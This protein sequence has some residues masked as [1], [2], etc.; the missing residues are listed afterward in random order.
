MRL[1]NKYLPDK[2]YNDVEELLERL[3]NDLD[4]NDVE[5]IESFYRD[6]KLKSQLLDGQVFNPLLVNH[7]LILWV[8]EKKRR[9]QY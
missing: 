6:G 7:P 9:K 4:E 3:F 1:K 2:M 5:L 8:L